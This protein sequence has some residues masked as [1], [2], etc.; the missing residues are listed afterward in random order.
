[1]DKFNLI[2]AGGR[3]FNDY[4]TMEAKLNGLVY[5]MLDSKQVGEIVIV[6][7]DAL[8]GA[9]PLGIHYGEENGLTIDKYPADWDNLD[10]PGAV[11]K[12]S[13]YGKSYNAIAGHMRNQVMADIA[14]GLIAFWDGKSRGTR[15]M[16]DRATL[17]GIL[18]Y[19]VY[20]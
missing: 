4:E 8:R 12:T 13:R 5:G 7:G 16:I 17:K 15:D 18:V 9:D 14:H 19:V 2:V 6:S 11:I 3:D 1:M 10:V 20:Y